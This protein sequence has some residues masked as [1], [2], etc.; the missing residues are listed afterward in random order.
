MRALSAVLLLA[1]L[2]VLL[3]FALQN[4]GS[5]DIRLMDYAIR[6]PLAAVVAGAYVLGMF[7]GWSVIGFMRRSW[8]R[9]HEPVR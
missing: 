7:S 5:V 9:V 1:F 6:F 2:G 8:H 3:M 4:R